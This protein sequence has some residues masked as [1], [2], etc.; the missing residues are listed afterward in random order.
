MLTHNFP[1]KKPVAKIVSGYSGDPDTRNDLEIKPLDLS[2]CKIGD[3]LYTQPQ[4]AQQG[5]VPEG[6]RE[7]LT[8][9]V[10]AMHDYEMSVDEDAPYKHRAM[11]DRAHALLSATPQSEGDGYFKS[12]ER[13]PTQKDADPFDRVLAWNGTQWFLSGWNSPDFARGWLS[14][15]QPTGLKRP[16]PPEEDSGDE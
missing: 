8:E 2:G 10:Q 4:S 11:M 3:L 16:Q 1:T 9:M 7:C 12:R 13:L 15:W 6:W 5:S 14:Y